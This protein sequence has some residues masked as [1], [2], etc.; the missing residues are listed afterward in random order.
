MKKIELLAPAGSLANLKAAVSKKADAVYL[1]LRK[2]SAR[3]YATNFNLEYLKEAVNICK[4]NDV[5]VYLAM[6]TLVKN[7]EIEAYFD[8]LNY[9]YS[10]GIDSVIIQEISFLDIIKKNFPDLRVHIST[11]AGIMNSSYA[12]LLKK[13]NRITLARELAFDEVKDIKRSFG[14]EVEMFGHGALCVSVSGQCLFSSLLGGRSGNRGRC[15]Q[16]CRKKYS[17]DYY[18]STKELCL[19]NEIPRII[20]V[21]V[22]AIKIEGRMRTPYYVANV[23][24]VYRE[25]IDSYYNGKFSVDSSMVKKLE[26]AFSREFTTGWFGKEAV[27]NRSKATGESSVKN[28]EF[29]DVKVKDVNVGRKK[30]NLDLPEIS[31]KEN[32]DKKLLVRVYNSRDALLA[33]ENGADV[34]YYDIFADDFNDVKIK[35]KLFG[36]VPRIVLDKDVDEILKRIKELELDGIFTGNLGIIANLDLPMHL[37]YNIN[38]FND[39]DIDYFSKKSVFSIISPELSI[40]EVNQFKDKN[41]GV[42]VHGKIRLMTLRHK[43][44]KERITDEKNCE[45]Y[46]NKIRNGVEILNKKE[47]SMLGKA[48]DLV[49]SGINNFYIDTDRAVGKIIRL[50]RKILDGEKVND[51]KIKKNYVLGW[52]FRGVE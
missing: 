43:L 45:F 19:I 21:G 10:V 29:Y 48:K 12:N 14:K 3:S 50:Y 39:Y 4:S 40:N 32:N 2:F 26:S 41:F 7:D 44:D 30:I 13:A 37:D 22:D 16:P 35:C 27:F 20:G 11:Q 1:G 15:A 17:G 18:L 23:T 31:K 34:V 33:C 24:S 51:S 38:C 47:L 36:V 9:A 8:Q 28:K 52:S 49:D 5:K 6:N 46:I 25:A 42:M